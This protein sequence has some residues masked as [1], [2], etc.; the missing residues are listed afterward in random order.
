MRVPGVSSLLRDA[1][2]KGNADVMEAR[3]VVETVSSLPRRLVNC[4]AL[5]CHSLVRNQRHL[6]VKMDKLSLVGFPGR[7]L[8]DGFPDKIT[9]AANND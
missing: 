2:V 9:G 8:Q 7:R 3:S 6:F 4:C 1:Q 5:C